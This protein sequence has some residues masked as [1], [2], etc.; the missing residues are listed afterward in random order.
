MLKS[1]ATAPE[2]LLNSL[3]VPN[4]IALS[5]DHQTL[6]VCD[7][8]TKNLWAYELKTDG[9]IKKGGVLASFNSE[10]DGVKTDLDNRIY[11]AASFDGVIILD[12]TGKKLDTIPV[13]EK[14]RNLCW[15]GN[16]RKDLFIT[17]GTSVYRIHLNPISPLTFNGLLG[18]PT[19]RSVAINVVAESSFSAFVEYGT[20]EGVYTQFT[21]TSTV[22][23]GV[24]Q[25][26][27]ILNLQPDTRYFYRIR[28]KPEGVDF[29]KALSM[30]SFHTQRNPSST[31]TFDVHAWIHP[32]ILS[33]IATLLQIRS[34]MPLI[35]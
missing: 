20:A 14:T 22:E 23:A 30:G 27:S 12:R 18:Q 26:I 5:P 25:V 28:V 15:G 11:V 8:D 33:P 17:A 19:D 21:E 3:S 10:I 6:Y 2:V 7:S 9:T 13:P 34:R 1:G 24:A 4:G 16:F 29:Y 35:S 32:P 31:F